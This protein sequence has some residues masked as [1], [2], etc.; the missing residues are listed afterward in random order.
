MASAKNYTDE[1]LSKLRQIQMDIYREIRRICEN[2]G[3]PFV[4]IAGTVL[5]AVRHNGYIPWDDDLDIAMMRCDYTRFLKYAKDEI[6]PKFFVQNYYTDPHYGNYFTKIRCNGTLFVQN[7]DKKDKSHHGIFVDVFPLDRVP[8]NL[9]ERIKYQKKLMIYY[10]IYMAKCNRGISGEIDSLKGKTNQVIRS[11]LH[12][13]L[14]SASKE[15]LFT[16]I[17]ELC[18]IYNDGNSSTLANAVVFAMNGGYF[19][20]ADMFPSV[21]HTFEGDTVMIPHDADKYLSQTY[22]DYMLLPPVDKRVNHRPVQ[23]RFEETE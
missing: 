19:E 22:G 12:V 9:K 16:K 11:V 2:H 14:L 6:N 21:T 5:G 23:L 18:Q 20:E 10:Q 3:I 8:D 13:L 1:E 15:K 4:A 7:I 17:D